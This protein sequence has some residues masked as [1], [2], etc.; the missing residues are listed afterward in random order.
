VRQPIEELGGMRDA[1]VE[2][3]QAVQ[4]LGERVDALEQQP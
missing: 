4:D 3:Q 1:L 2:T